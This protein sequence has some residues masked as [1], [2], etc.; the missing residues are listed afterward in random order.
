MCTGA[1]R[2]FY[3]ITSSQPCM[4][5]GDLSLPPDGSCGTAHVTSAQVKDTPAGKP[6]Q[7]LEAWGRH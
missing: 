6:N 4:E 1:W 3:A 7:G 2:G 5:C